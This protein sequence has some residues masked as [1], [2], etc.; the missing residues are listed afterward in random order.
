MSKQRARRREERE[1]AAAE[2]RRRREARRRRAQGRAAAV[3]SVT[4]PASRA[5]IRFARWW[6]RT[7]PPQ[8]PFARRRRRQTFVVASIFLA[9]QVLAWWLVPSWGVRLAVLLL[10][11]LLVPVVRVLL[12]DRR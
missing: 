10:S 9:T 2:E 1:A 8:D 4:A 5:R 12:F 11:C 6:R 7:Y 3:G